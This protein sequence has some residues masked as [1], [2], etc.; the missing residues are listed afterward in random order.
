MGTK[1]NANRLGWR[2][3][4]FWCGFGDRMAAIPDRVGADYT[5]STRCPWMR[6]RHPSVSNDLEN[7]S[8]CHCVGNDMKLLF[9]TFVIS[10]A[11]RLVSECFG[12]EK[13]TRLGVNNNAEPYAPQ[14]SRASSPC[15][16]SQR[17]GAGAAPAGRQSW[18]GF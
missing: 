16:C 1:Q 15:C 14:L 13:V 12:L 2:S 5:D 6:F 10:C 7:S 17:L 8:T 11:I 3:L 9:E 4:R 18:T